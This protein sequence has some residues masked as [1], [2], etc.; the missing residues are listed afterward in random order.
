VLYDF[1]I[2]IE[3]EYVDACIV[4]TT[5]P[6]LMAMQDDHVVFRDCAFELS[7][8]AQIFDGHALK[9]VDKRLFAVCDMWIMLDVVVASELFDGG[10]G[11]ALVKHQVIESES[12]LFTV[13]WI[14]GHDEPLFSYIHMIAATDY[15][16]AA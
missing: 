1:T 10:T 15:A 11:F 16:V 4:I 2:I 8:L 6:N 14:A 12:V 13:L 5:R 9:V 3:L 7:D